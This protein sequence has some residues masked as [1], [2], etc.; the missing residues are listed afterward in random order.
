MT[1][2]IRTAT[3]A[4]FTFAYDHTGDLSDSDVDGEITKF[5]LVN[6][7]QE[8]MIKAVERAFWR[9]VY[10]LQADA[11]PEYVSVKEAA[12]AKN[13]SQQAIFDILKNDRRKAEIFPS[14]KKLYE[15]KRSPWLIQYDELERW[16]PSR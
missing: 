9:G 11:Q 8:S 16:T 4:G 1:E 3:I 14:A 5:C 10:A 6:D 13:V 12:Q 15:G 2:I 7:V